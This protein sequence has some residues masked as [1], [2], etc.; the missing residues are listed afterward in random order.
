MSVN[1]IV[2]LASSLGIAPSTLNTT[3]RNG[4]D[5]KMCYAECGRFSG[6]WRNLLQSQFPELENLQVTWCK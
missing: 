1:K 5:T 4:K 6:R 3:V 2:T